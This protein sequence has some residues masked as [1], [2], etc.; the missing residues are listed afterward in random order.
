M[1]SMTAIT[2]LLMDDCM[3]VIQVELLEGSGDLVSR[4]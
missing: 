1:C 3:E 4:L 2:Y